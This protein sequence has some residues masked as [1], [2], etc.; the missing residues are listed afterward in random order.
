MGL[1][2]ASPSPT[3]AARRHRVC[4]ASPTPAHVPHA[5]L[6]DFIRTMRAEPAAEF[7][8]DDAA[9][10][11]GVPPFAFIRSFKRLTGLSPQRFRAALRIEHAKRLLVDTDRPVT[12]I[13]F[14]VGYNSLGTFVRTFTALVGISPGQLRRLARG[15]DPMAILGTTP[16]F[17]LPPADGPVIYG[18][19][20]PPFPH[21]ALLAVGLFPQGLPAGLPF[22]GCFV[23]PGAPDFRLAW[24]RERRRTSLLAAAVGA[25]SAIDAWA[26][27]LP[28]VEVCSLSL[29][30]PACAGKDEPIRIRLRPLAITDPPF[31]T[32]VPLLMLLQSW[33]SALQAHEINVMAEKR[34]ALPRN[35]SA[36]GICNPGE[37]PTF[38]GA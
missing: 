29:P 2:L 16:I 33:R 25:F 34:P 24:P 21:G 15:C 5:S 7:H 20:E 22:D 8:T 10:G 4:A 12:D 23:D 18:A 28:D 27:R 35:R 11:F 19:I 36:L 31:L 17:G 14:D 30:D 37:A 38:E 26:G 13:S 3:V 1:L 9:A 32:P 6:R